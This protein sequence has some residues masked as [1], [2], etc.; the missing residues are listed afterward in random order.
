MIKVL[1]VAKEFDCSKF[2]E[3]REGRRLGVLKSM[4]FKLKLKLSR[5]FLKDRAK[6][7][8]FMDQRG[9]EV[10]SIDISRPI[11]LSSSN[12]AEMFLYSSTEGH[13]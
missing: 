9:S 7:P 4:R 8:P 10:L 13:R 5:R 1:R 3:E 2:D 12:R 11:M 6:L